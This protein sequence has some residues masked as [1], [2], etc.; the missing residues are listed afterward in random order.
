M[1]VISLVNTHETKI[2]PALQERTGQSNVF[3]S[4]ALYYENCESCPRYLGIMGLCD[5]HLFSVIF[6]GLLSENWFTA[7]AFKITLKTDLGRMTLPET[8]RKWNEL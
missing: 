6:H 5:A 2:G 7:T 3:K 4:C 1:L 8:I